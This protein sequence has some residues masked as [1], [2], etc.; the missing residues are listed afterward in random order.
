MFYIILAVV[1]GGVIGYQ[2]HKTIVAWKVRKLL[3]FLENHLDVKI[4]EKTSTFNLSKPDKT[5]SLFTETNDD[6]IMLYK[7]GTN[8]FVCQAKTI[9][10]LATNSFIFNKIDV[11]SVDHNKETLFFVD[12]KVQKR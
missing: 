6:N 8:Q 2:I 10:E 5:I 4:I 7:K 12:G 11:A 9:E 3:R 1:L